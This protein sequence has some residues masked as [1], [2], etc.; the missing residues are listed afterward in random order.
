M[1][2][3]RVAMRHVCEI[4]GGDLLSWRRGHVMSGVFGVPR[5]LNSMIAV[6]R[7]AFGSLPAT[8][9]KAGAAVERSPPTKAKVQMNKVLIHAALLALLGASPTMAADVQCSILITNNSG[10][11]I[12]NFFSLHTGYDNW[13]GDL[14]GRSFLEANTRTTVIVDPSQHD[15]RVRWENGQTAELR[16]VDAC[17]TSEVIARRWQ[18]NIVNHR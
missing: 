1:P 11:R 12:E 16:N 8:S 4:R 7:S 15:F 9:S 3:E 13:R 14:L 5:V 18:L 6:V 10:A 17:P 2:A